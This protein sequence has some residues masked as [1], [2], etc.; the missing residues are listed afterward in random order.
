MADAEIL[1]EAWSGPCTMV[2]SV[3]LGGVVETVSISA[4]AP[5]GRTE[6]FFEL[7]SSFKVAERDLLEGVVACRYWGVDEAMPDIG[8]DGSEDLLSVRAAEYAEKE[9]WEQLTA[10]RKYPKSKLS[11]SKAAFWDSAEK[12]SR[13]AKGQVECRSSLVSF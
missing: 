9:Y 7:D 2:C 8:K 4:E 1:R 12:G 5:I 11:F 13:E 6:V 10:V 3:M